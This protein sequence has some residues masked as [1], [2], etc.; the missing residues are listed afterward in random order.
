MRAFILGGLLIGSGAALVAACGDDSTGAGG[1]GAGSNVTASTSPSATNT[2][3]TSTGASNCT[4]L[5]VTGVARVGVDTDNGVAFYQLTLGTALGGAGDDNGALQIYD[6]AATTGTIDLAAGDNANYKACPQCVLLFE[7]TDPDTGA[8]TKSYFQT[9]GT[10]ELGNTTVPAL[11]GSLKDVT[12]VE[13]TIAP[14]PDFTSTPVAGGACYHITDAE[15]AFE[16]APAAWTCDPALYGD[17][18]ACDCQD[19]GV[20]DADCADTTL[21]VDGCLEGQTTCNADGKTCAGVPTAWTCDAA[22]YNGGAGN[23]CDCNCGTPD[24][25]CALTGEVLAGC[26]ASEQCSDA[27]TCY[28][29]GWTCPGTYYGDTDCDCGCGVKD[30]DCADL[31]IASCDYCDDTGSCAPTGDDCMTDSAINAT[32]NAVCN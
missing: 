2:G 28:P 30:S 22:K 8:S 29:M 32:N 21:V 25:D 20:V 5:T 3:S 9:K 31:L 13:V 18:V 26:A 11:T 23:G 7:D 27:G 6:I 1:S 14:P 12:L 4:E 24:P 15:F 10:L 19:C 16:E 17:K